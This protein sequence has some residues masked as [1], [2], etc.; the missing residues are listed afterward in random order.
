MRGRHYPHLR[1]CFEESLE[2]FG[3]NDFFVIQKGIK[4]ET[5]TPSLRTITS[6]LRLSDCD[7]EVF[8]KFKDAILTQAP[9]CGPRLR[10]DLCRCMSRLWA[11]HFELDMEKDIAFEIGRFYYCV[12]NYSKALKFYRLSIEQVGEHHVTHHN[13]GLCLYSLGRFE[14]AMTAFE[15]SI[16][17]NPAYEKSRTWLAR[18]KSEMETRNLRLATLSSAADPS[19]SSSVTVLQS[20]NGD[21]ERMIIGGLSN[22]MIS[23]GSDDV[24]VNGSDVSSP[25]TPIDTD[26]VHVAVAIPVSEDD[27]T[28]TRVAAVAVA[29]ISDVAT[30]SAYSTVFARVD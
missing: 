11:N 10:A 9:T 30:G 20:H 29:T 6:L 16:A 28:P 18:C 7:P 14:P 25:T 27:L 3:P 26:D 21:G 23:T 12:R 4:E 8:H 2:G 17:Y 24:N 5:Q 13:V 15:A 22:L 19:T 1:R